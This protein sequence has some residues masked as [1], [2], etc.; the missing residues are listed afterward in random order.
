MQTLQRDKRQN[1]LRAARNDRA[2]LEGVSEHYPGSSTA[3]R[4]DSAFTHILNLPFT[5]SLTGCLTRACGLAG[6]VTASGPRLTTQ[7]TAHRA[8]NTSEWASPIYILV[9]AFFRFAWRSTV[10]AHFLLPILVL[11]QG[12]SAVARGGVG[13]VGDEDGVR[14]MD[15]LDSGKEEV[16][17]EGDVVRWCGSDVHEVEKREQR[18]TVSGFSPLSTAITPSLRSFLR[19]SARALMPNGWAVP[20]SCVASS[21][22]TMTG[23]RKSVLTFCEP[24]EIGW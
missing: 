4:F 21:C 24:V 15:A 20:F 13:M 9:C 18:T 17:W 8:A 19:G 6:A 7:A 23:S 5:A 3:S 12:P 11:S 14:A 2:L 10:R 22:D 1:G 16:S